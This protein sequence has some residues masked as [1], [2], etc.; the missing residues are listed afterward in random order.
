MTLLAGGLASAQQSPSL[1]AG[2]RVGTRARSAICADPDLAQLEWKLVL[3]ENM[4]PAIEDDLLLTCDGDKRPAV[5]L[6]KV[7]RN[8][9]SE[10]ERGERNMAIDAI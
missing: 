2:G 3:L 9:I 5:C 1:W 10:N 7:F 8:S 4:P 6:R